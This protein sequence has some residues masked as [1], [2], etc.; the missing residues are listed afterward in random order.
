MGAVPNPT[1]L[2]GGLPC[3]AAQTEQAFV[4]WAL[5]APEPSEEAGP[6]AGGSGAPRSGKGFRGPFLLLLPFSLAQRRRPAEEE[7]HRHRAST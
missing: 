2:L 1:T 7:G 6:G 5:L 3:P 4:E